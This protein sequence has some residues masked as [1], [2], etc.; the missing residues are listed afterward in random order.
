MHISRRTKVVA[1]VVA[2]TFS[3]SSAGAWLAMMVTVK[4]T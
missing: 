4:P 3:H 2:A 1:G